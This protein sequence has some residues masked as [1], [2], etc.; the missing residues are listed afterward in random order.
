MWIKI[1]IVVIKT[2]TLHGLKC[3]L[4]LPSLIYPQSR[5]KAPSVNR[6]C[7]NRK[8]TSPQLHGYFRRIYHSQVPE[9]RPKLNV[10]H[11]TWKS[12]RRNRPLNAEKILW[13]MPLLSFWF[14]EH[15]EE[16]WVIYFGLKYTLNLKLN[17]WYNQYFITVLV[18]FYLC[19]EYIILTW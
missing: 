5:T 13:K 3:L 10:N 1:S 14:T 4:S 19:P 7:L 12:T 18:F 8:S 9:A 16:V 2:W 15:L 17:V 11:E 6:I